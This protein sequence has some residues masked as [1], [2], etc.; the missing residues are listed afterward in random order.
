MRINSKK[1]RYAVR[2]VFRYFWKYRERRP[3][4]KVAF[5]SRIV[6]IDADSES[7]AKAKAHRLFERENRER[8]TLSAVARES[9]TYVG[10]SGILEFGVEMES[11]EVWWEFTD[12]RPRLVARAPVA[13]RR[14]R[15]P[16][17]PPE[18]HL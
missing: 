6:L 3:A 15:R 2:G 11:G 17:A 1:R 13:A 7:I 16:K 10:I 12:Q 18:G 8:T 14:P 9:V 4:A 5:E